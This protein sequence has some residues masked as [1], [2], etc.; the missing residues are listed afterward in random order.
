VSATNDDKSFYRDIAK[1]LGVSININSKA[2]ELRQRIEDVLQTGQLMIV[3]D[4]AHYL[5]P[6][7]IDPRTLP[8]RINWLMT[9]L[10]NHGVPAS[11]VTTPQ[12]LA[13]QK[14]IEEKTR[15][16]SEQFIG[17][18]SHYKRLPNTLAQKDLLAVAESY[19]PDADKLCLQV[20]VEYAQ[21]SKKF[22]AGIDAVARR[23]RFL[24][25]RAGRSKVL[26]IDVKR[27]VLDG[28]I[29]SDNALAAAIAP[30]TRRRHAAYIDPIP[31]EDAAETESA[32][33]T[34]ERFSP[35]SLVP[36]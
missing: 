2:Q 16:T 4:E 10:I 28:V 8:V 9:A 13:G 29:P 14:T 25:A 21:T 36:A 31:A 19:L 26:P 24:A 34:S 6:N 1:S 17:R 27:A 35:R 12:F 18:I 30:K 22:R 20:L 23:A 15:W 3:F 5:W 33:L 32:V 7:L 11:L